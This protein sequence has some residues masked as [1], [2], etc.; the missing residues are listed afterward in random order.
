MRLA[1]LTDLHL[2]IPARPRA[3]SLLN[4]RVLGYFSWT[5][6]RRRRHRI[7]ALEAITADCAA[8]GADFTALS[9]DLVNISL[10]AE[11]SAANQWV[12]RHFEVAATGFC[13]G[14]HDAYV[15]TP[16][17]T[18]LGLLAD[19]MAGARPRAPEG[20]LTAA[21]G[22]EDFPF[23]RTV[24][25]VDLIF[26]NSS[27]PTAPGLASGRLGPGQIERI[28]NALRRS[29][30]AQRARVLILH[31]PVTDGATPAR[32]ALGDR[33]ALRAA[34]ARAGV[35]LVL[36][37]HTH[38]PVWASVETTAGPR[39]VV[40]GASASHP[41]GHGKYTAA[42]YNIYSID[43]ARDGW[44]IAAEIRELDPASGRVNTVERRDLLP[45]ETP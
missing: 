37:G 33:A 2:P 8:S 5:R 23:V 31:H 30:E 6:N 27:P 15:K 44:R 13:P 1:H 22:P 26:A 7:E 39:P 9:G 24:G 34:I 35:E 18:G 4:K 40:G 10:P 28:E 21:T 19:Y 41:V 14:N 42:R 11:F 36:H 45:F 12:R 16:W 17:E 3:A 29:G 20:A 32:K 25:D 43:R 38:Y